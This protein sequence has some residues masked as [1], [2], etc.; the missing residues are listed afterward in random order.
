MGK[1]IKRVC[2]KAKRFIKLDNDYQTC[3]LFDFGVQTF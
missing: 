1:I 3:N 2:D